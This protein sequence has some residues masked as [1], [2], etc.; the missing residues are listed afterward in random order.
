MSLAP[1]LSLLRRPEHP[2]AHWRSIKRASL[3]RRSARWNV[4][5][6]A[7]AWDRRGG[8]CPGTNVRSFRRC[9]AFCPYARRSATARAAAHLRT[10]AGVAVAAGEELERSAVPCLRLI[11][12]GEVAGRR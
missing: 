1:L 6:S 7:I 2:T 3:R 8:A 5:P 4:A 10:G 12:V 9:S 11:A